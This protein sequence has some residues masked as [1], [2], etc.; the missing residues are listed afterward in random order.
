M[1]RRQHKWAKDADRLTC[2]RCGDA[3]KEVRP[4]FLIGQP[5]LRMLGPFHARCADW[6]AWR[7]L[8]GH[9]EDGQAAGD[10]YASIL[11]GDKAEV[12]Q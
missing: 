3:I 5:S 11:P 8:W 2:A 7:A 4:V 9:N 1:R 6:L 12:L 10:A